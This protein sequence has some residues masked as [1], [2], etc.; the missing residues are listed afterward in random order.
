MK[1]N[2]KTRILSIFLAAAMLLPLGACSQGG[3]DASS[4]S[5][6]K[7]NTSKSQNQTQ[8]NGKVKLTYWAGSGTEERNTYLKKVFDQYSKKHPNVSIEYLGVPG[9]A[10][11]LDQK[12]NMAIAGDEVPDV[13]QGFLSASYITRKIVEPLDDY[14]LNSSL[15]DDMDSKY[16]DAFRSVDYKN[17]KLYAVPAPI[18]VQMI[19]IRPDLIKAAGLSPTMDTWNDFFTIAD[20]TTQPSKGIYGYIIRGGKGAAG[21]L[22]YQMYSYSG[23][24][25]FFDKNGKC[26]INNSKNVEYM[27]KYLGRFKKDTSADDLN[28]SWT[29]MS[30]QF[31]SGKAVTLI[32]NTGSAPGNFKAFK[33]DTSKVMGIAYPKSPYTKKVTVPQPTLNG[34]MIMAGS[35]NKA[36][37]W[38]LIEHMQSPDI[39][40]EY[41]KIFGQLPVTKSAQSQDW[42]Q[43]SPYMKAAADCMNS[44]DTVFTIFPY[45]MSNFN[46]IES[47]EDTQIQQV[48]LGKLTAKQMLDDWAKKLQA[49]Y[50]KYKNS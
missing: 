23:V 40:G 28:K 5:S 38:K 35:K 20:K 50:D 12:L 15:K 43:K 6:P 32:H 29:A 4:S 45:Y 41:A 9:S 3:S 14:F 26:T 36:E 33:Q 31:Q 27:E 49:E 46:K 16:T 42:I 39:A 24:T 47:S 48:M 7:G 44:S 11:D 22:E 13:V 8:S 1:R 37:A 18:N 34:Y 10:S 19:Y 17:K 25:S 30:A 2:V 21:A